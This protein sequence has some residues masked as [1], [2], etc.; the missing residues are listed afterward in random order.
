M[1][2]KI[3]RILGLVALLYVAYGA[4]LYFLQDKLLFPGT[5]LPVPVRSHVVKDAQLIDLPF[6]GGRSVAYFLPAIATPPRSKT[7]VM[8]IA[9]GNGE[10]ADYLVDAFSGWRSM[11]IALLIVEYPGYGRAPGKP[12]DE[13]IRRTMVAA[14]DWLAVRPDVDDKRIVAH[15]I[16]LGGGAVGLLLRERPLAGAMLHATFTS[17]RTF[18]PQYGLPGFLLRNEMNTL[19][20]VERTKVPVLVI[21]GKHDSIIAPE[22]GVAL[23]KAAKMKDF[24]LWDCGHGCF[25]DEGRPLF[26]VTKRFL[27]KLGVVP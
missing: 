7:G 25:Q 15:G 6:D 21:H 27:Q 12:G 2:E 23:A 24:S 17:L 20:S 14:Y 22:H 10:L 19:E 8:I 9:H 11:G 13:S 18:P 16:S 1:T 3:L 4:T 5:V 26:A